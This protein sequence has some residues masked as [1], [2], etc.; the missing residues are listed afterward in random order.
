MFRVHIIID[1]NI[2]AVATGIAEHNRYALDF[3][4]AE[5]KYIAHI[6]SDDPSVE[7]R[8]HVRIDRFAVD[9]D[10]TLVMTASK[11]GGQAVRI[12]PAASGDEYPRYK[13]NPVMVAPASQR[14]N[15]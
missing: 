9:R 5:K 15:D 12:V 2:F 4:E 3:I 7:T 14:A 6:Y 10:T 13:V 1:P 11:Q 8:T